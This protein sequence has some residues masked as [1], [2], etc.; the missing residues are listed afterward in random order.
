MEKLAIF[1][2]GKV[3]NSEFPNWPQY[4]LNDEKAL[5]DV[6]H[7]GNWSYTKG[8]VK[9][10]KNSFIERFQ[11]EIARRTEA[12][13]VL[14]VSN[15]TIALEMALKALNIQ[16]GEEVIVSP[17]SFVSSASSILAVGAIPVFADIDY[18]T[19]NLDANSIRR[20]I[21]KKTRAVMPVHFGG[22]ACEM[23]K[24][25]ALA[26]EYE[27]KVVEDAA[28][29]LGATYH[30]TPVGNIG[31]IGCFSLQSSK[32]LTCGEGGIVCTQ[33]EEYYKSLYS[34]H[35]VGRVIGGA[36]YEHASWGSNYRI[37]EFQAALAYSQLSRLNDQ[38]RRRYENARYLDSKLKSIEGIEVR[39]VDRGD[40][41]SVDHLY[42]F[43]YKAD[44]FKGLS[45][46]RF[47]MLMNSEGI[48]C[49][50]GYKAPIYKLQL[51]RNLNTEY[52]TCEISELTCKEAVWLQNNVLLGEKEQIDKIVQ[53]I[54]KI[55]YFLDDLVR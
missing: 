55:R 6:L 41:R 49:T 14:A 45:R 39:K 16:Q 36:W 38:N 31:A 32:N 18:D 26:K 4:G 42:C 35:N 48:P 9:E 37:T 53:A 23:D 7:S 30:N 43:R 24:I 5:L 25:C 29:A 52:K 12:K 27:L 20:C 44:K 54:Q 15:G 19:W 50:E 51:F 33:N 47:I 10:D 13:Y 34:L 2:G 22:Q 40:Q 21:T 8:S 1:G 11:N 17:Y 3:N 46:K 28:Q